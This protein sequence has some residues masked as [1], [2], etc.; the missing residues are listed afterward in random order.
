MVSAGNELRRMWSQHF[1]VLYQHLGTEEQKFY[2]EQ[3]ECF[4][5]IQHYEGLNKS[6]KNRIAMTCVIT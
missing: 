5:G 1:K 4:T 6:M 2:S 3:E